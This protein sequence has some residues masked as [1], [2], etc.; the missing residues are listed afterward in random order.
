MPTNKI[1]PSLLISCIVTYLITFIIHAC[2]HNIIAYC[3]GFNDAPW[4][5][6]NESKLWLQNVHENSEF[7]QL[8][9]EG[10]FFKIGM[11]GIAG[12]LSNWVLLVFALFK[13]SKAKVHEINFY[14]WF[15]I[16]N[17]IVVFGYIPHHLINSI[18]LNLI[19]N[20]IGISVWMTYVIG[21]FIALG[22]LLIVCYKIMPDMFDELGII[23]PTQKRIY[24]TSVL[25]LVLFYSTI[26][27]VLV[28]ENYYLPGSHA[29]NIFSNPLVYV[30]IAIFVLVSYTIKLNDASPK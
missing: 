21:G 17:L 19:F 28:D 12:Y 3:Y 18:H 7:L 20:S 15:A 16:W 13:L 9:Q 6:I 25:F 5:I 2:V 26:R 14:F 27:Y 11:V 1:L 24:F 10:N 4:I 23:D 8:D 30:K 29:Y 22:I